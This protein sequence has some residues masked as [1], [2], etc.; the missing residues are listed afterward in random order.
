MGFAVTFAVG[1][2]AGALLR[3]AWIAFV[4]IHWEETL[5]RRTYQLDS[6]PRAHLV[7]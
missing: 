1:T 5:A 2:F 3:I 7:Q 4:A 6:L